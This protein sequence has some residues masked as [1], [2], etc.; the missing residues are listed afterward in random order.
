MNREEYLKTLT[1]QIRCKKARAAVAEEIQ[2]HIEDQKQ[3]Y[4]SSGADEAS[5]EDMAVREMGDPVEAGIALDTIHRPKMAWG[6]I[7]LISVLSILGLGLQYLVHID[8]SKLQEDVNSYSPSVAR[9]AASGINPNIFVV[10][11]LGLAVMILVCHLDYT[12]V[13][14]KAKEITVVLFLVIVLWKWAAG[15][16]I[17]GLQDWVRIG[18]IELS[19]RM[20]IYLFIPL[21][22]GVLYSNRGKGYRGILENVIWMM[23]AL[24]ISISVPSAV[25]M[26]VLFLTFAVIL[27]I[28][29]SHNWY[30]VSRK[31]TIGGLWT[32]IVLLPAFLYILAKSFGNTYQAER[33]QAYGGLLTQWITKSNENPFYLAASVNQ[34]LTGGRLIGAGQLPKGE[35]AA[36]VLGQGNSYMLT[37]VAAFYGILVAAALAGAV[38]FV[39]FRFFRISLRQKNQLGMIMGTGCSTAFL[40]QAAAYIVNNLG[41]IPTEI[42]VPFI[43]YGGAGTVVTYILLGV[44]LSIY[45]YQNVLPEN[46]LPKV[47]KTEKA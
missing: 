34:M 17:N 25:T 39:F 1:E 26:I 35:G 6:M 13:G 38:L 15:L 45:R 20:L 44:L 10:I 28:A 47:R 36:V 14:L 16:Q 18:S 23:P 11:I 22:A 3:A 5:A 2:A 41:I 32:V 12:R 30:K 7:A 24:F 43:S 8:L 19:I 27:T 46:P 40:L 33:L 31:R 42:N 37:Y 29:V 4:L 9:Y 21:Y